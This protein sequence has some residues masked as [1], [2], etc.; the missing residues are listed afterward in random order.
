[1]VREPISALWEPREKM[2][3][4]VYIGDG[5]YA[6]FDGFVLDEFKG[7]LLIHRTDR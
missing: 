7:R 3:N 1:M 4:P 2:E 6:Y 5:V